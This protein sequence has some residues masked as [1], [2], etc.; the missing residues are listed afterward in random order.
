MGC[1]YMIRNIVN[2]KSYIG[3]TIQNWERRVKCHFWEARLTIG[4]VRILKNMVDLLQPNI[5]LKNKVKID[6][7]S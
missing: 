1:I 6:E 4:V 7:I 5:L 2:H 3:Q